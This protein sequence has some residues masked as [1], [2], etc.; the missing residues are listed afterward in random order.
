MFHFAIIPHKANAPLPIDT[1]AHLPFAI[2]KQAF[3]VVARRLS[4]VIHC[5]CSIQN[6][7]LTQ[8]SILYIGWK[9]SGFHF[10]PDFFRFLTLK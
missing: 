6:A 8:Y 9:F 3:Q 4:Q 5:L 7:Q 2:M 1:Y 10:I